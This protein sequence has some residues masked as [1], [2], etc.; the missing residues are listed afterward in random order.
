M[1]YIGCTAVRLSLKDSIMAALLRVIA[2][3]LTV[4]IDGGVFGV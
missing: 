2:S 3:T 4:A 1:A